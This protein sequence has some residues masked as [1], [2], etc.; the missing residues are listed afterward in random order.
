MSQEYDT[1]ASDKGIEKYDDRMCLR[2]TGMKMGMH[3]SV[4]DRMSREH[5]Y[6][7]D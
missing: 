4:N 5:F 6:K 2:A 3:G 1:F 7:C